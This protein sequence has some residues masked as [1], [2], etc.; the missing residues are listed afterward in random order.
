MQT[1]EVISINLWQILISIANLL[2]MFLILKK[3]LFAPVKKV[4]ELRSEKID[5]DYSDAKKA[6]EDAERDA[7][8]YSEKLSGAQDEAEVILKN[9][10]ARADKMESEIIADASAKAAN[11]IRRAD[12]DIAQ[13]KKKAVNDI[14]NEISSMSVDIAERMLGREI[15]EDDHKALI[16]DFISGI[17]D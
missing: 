7:R 4:F 3:F 16:D 8:L 11:M 15:N 10:R 6:K 5:R 12:A 13:E 9:A 2:I 1:L 17:G 14:K